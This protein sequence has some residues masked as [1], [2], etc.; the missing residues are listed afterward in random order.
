MPE[1]GVDS[2]LCDNQ[3][4]GLRVVTVQLQ[5]FLWVQ[6]DANKQAF[7]VRGNADEQAFESNSFRGCSTFRRAQSHNLSET[8]GTLVIEDFLTALQ[9]RIA[10]DWAQS[11][12]AKLVRDDALGNKTLTFEQYGTW[13]A[14][15]MHENGL[16]ATSK[17]SGVFT[18]M[19]PK[20]EKQPAGARKARGG[21][22][23]PCKKGGEKH[24]REPRFCFRL[25]EAITGKRISTH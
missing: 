12:L 21:N 1:F 10:P 11:E 22:L 23:C 7:Q 2:I 20:P 16:G 5:G 3:A 13:F 6:G 25:R 24:H 8:E 9:K 18:T 15:L 14:A 17:D 19:F 4:Y